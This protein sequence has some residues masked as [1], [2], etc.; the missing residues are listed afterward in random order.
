MKYGHED[1][2]AGIGL[3]RD[4]YAEQ[5]AEPGDIKT[6]YM[7]T[8]HGEVM[9]ESENPEQLAKEVYAMIERLH[10][11]YSHLNRIGMKRPTADDPT[12]DKE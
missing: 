10:T 4:V 9:L 6:N 1:K 5:F 8:H 11:V 7:V 2:K 12:G 3:S